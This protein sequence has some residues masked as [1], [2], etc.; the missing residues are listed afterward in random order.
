MDALDKLRLLEDKIEVYEKGDGEVDALKMRIEQL[1][2]E[3]EVS[4]VELRIRQEDVDKENDKLAK[5]LDS[6]KV[7]KI[8]KLFVD[9]S[10][11][12]FFS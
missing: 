12:F 1:E 7:N 10:F 3:L 11:F 4:K 8:G 5:Q 6:L 9:F 2:A